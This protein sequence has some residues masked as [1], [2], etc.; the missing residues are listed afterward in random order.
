MGCLTRHRMSAPAVSQRRCMA[1]PLLLA[2]RWLYV[3]GEED[4]TS[5]PYGDTS[6]IKKAPKEGL[7]DM[8]EKAKELDEKAKEMFSMNSVT[9]GMKA[10]FGKGALKK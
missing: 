4:F 3:S 8:A 7:A 5:M 9:D 2:R 1:D 10:V 6:P